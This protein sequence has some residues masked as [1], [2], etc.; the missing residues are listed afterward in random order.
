M[1]IEIIVSGFGGQGVLLAGLLLAEAA[2]K[3]GLYT[4]WFPS[5]GAEMRGGTANSTVIVSSDEIGSPLVSNPNAL[6]A[7]NETSFNKFM[8]KVVNEAIIIANSSAI[9]KDKQCGIKPYFVPVTDIAN[10]KIGNMKS[11]NMVAVGALIKAFEIH[12]GNMCFISIKSIILTCENVFAAKPK[13]IEINKM[14][15]EAGYDFIK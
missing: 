8:P 7:L 9:S 12:S 14:A 5:Y 3:E 2:M 15:V 13:L 11:L 4:T 10:K 1:Q 6:I